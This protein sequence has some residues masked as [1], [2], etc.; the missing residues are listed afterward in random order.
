MPTTI[1][2]RVSAI[3]KELAKLRLQ[4]AEKRTKLGWLDHFDGSFENDPDFEEAMQ[5]GREW[6]KSQDQS[7]ESREENQ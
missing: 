1:E 4:V 7:P 3:E 6:R 5:L 2:D